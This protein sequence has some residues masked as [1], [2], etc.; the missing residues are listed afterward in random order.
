M[1]KQKVHSLKIDGV[2]E[3]IL[4]RHWLIPEF[5][6]E[7]VWSPGQV[8]SFIHSIVEGR[9]IGMATL[10]E[11][12]EKVVLPLEP[13]S[14]IDAD[15]PVFFGS[16]KGYPAE[17]YAVIDGKQRC[18]ALA[19][20]FG[21][22]RTTDGRRK[23]TGRYFLSLLEEDEFAPI[24]Y[25]K[26]PDVVR[27]GYHTDAGAIGN[28]M[29]PL[30][31]SQPG[32][33]VYEQWFRYSKSLA[34]AEYYNGN[35]PNDAELER[36][37]QII[38][39]ALKGIL[40]T[41][42]AFY[43]IPSRYNLGEICE[44]FE[45]LN[46]TGTKVS[47]VDLIHSQLYSE[48]STSKATPFQ[49]REWISELGEEDGG[50]GWSSAENRPELIAQFA[51]ASYVAQQTDRPAPRQIANKKIVIS[52]IKAQD[53]LATPYEFWKEWSADKSRIA[54]FLKD[55]QLL[56]A[57]GLFPH[58]DCPYP[59]TAAIYVALRWSHWIDKPTEWSIPDLDVVYRP[60]FW[61]N[62]LSQRYDQGFL[63]QVGQD[64]RTIQELLVQRENYA[65]RGKWA[66]YV[67]D[68]LD[69]YLKKPLPTRSYLVDML[70]DGY[71]GGALQKALFLPMLAG[72]EVDVFDPEIVI[73]FPGGNDNRAIHHIYP[74]KWCRT[75]VNGRLRS[76]LDPDRA[77]RD[78][79]NS[80]SNQMPLAKRTNSVW[81][82]AIPAQFLETRDIECKTH[83]K[84]LRSVYISEDAF[85]VLAKSGQADPEAFWRLRADAIA[86]DLLERMKVSI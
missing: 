3:N 84:Q 63:T 56:T 72:V 41:E 86:T 39:K 52:S 30:S 7:F 80:I 49:L 15:G 83:G 16:T 21:G 68:Q 26:E 65:N 36:R 19:V 81:S 33:G 34:K 75:N 6:R 35:V 10:W 50:N 73:S 42:L 22:F 45:T 70:T 66:G 47:T 60:F 12:P 78:W 4:D 58:S 85:K 67:A 51:T 46:T 44:I 25:L 1:R 13:L 53:L 40:D 76:V 9:P 14:L 24:K 38:A 57:G 28:G 48:S 8:C 55:F 59:A 37:E 64:I 82:S 31:S 2:I 11:Q 74:K 23:H 61:R 5:Q 79:V 17:K 69:V 71:P 18:T 43:V 62:A 54:A 32:E 29:L 27:K 77:G 20:A